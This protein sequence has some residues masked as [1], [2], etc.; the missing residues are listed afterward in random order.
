M[1]SSSEASDTSGLNHSVNSSRSSVRTKG[2]EVDPKNPILEPIAPAAPKQE[3]LAPRSPGN[4]SIASLK[5]EL[6]VQENILSLLQREN[7][8][9]ITNEKLLKK[10]IKELEAKNANLEA[11][12]SIQC[13]S[14]EF[15]VPLKDERND[16]IRDLRRTIS[17]LQQALREA[18]S[19]KCSLE[20]QVQKG[21][22]IRDTE[23]EIHR[24]AVKDKASVIK[25]EITATE[26]PAP[27]LSV[28]TQTTSIDYGNQ[29]IELVK[30]DPASKKGELGDTHLSLKRRIQ[31][32]QNALE[33]KDRCAEAAIADLK[34]ETSKLRDYYESVI[35][36]ISN[37]SSQKVA[38]DSGLQAQNN[39][40][41]SRVE[42]L[43]RSIAE[44]NLSNREMIIS[45]RS[46]RMALESKVAVSNKEKDELFVALHRKEEEMKIMQLRFQEELLARLDALRQEHNGNLANI[47]REHEGDLKRAAATKFSSQFYKDV[48][49]KWIKLKK[50]SP[51]TFLSTVVDRLTFLESYCAQKDAEMELSI[52]QVVQ[53]ADMELKLQKQREEMRI[54]EKNLQIQNFQ[55][56]LHHLMQL[57][58]SIR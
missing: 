9:L 44:A 17:E 39:A 29:P 52:G 40:L 31:Q 54:Q 58:S 37:S 42:E 46:E 2:S 51:D 48:R 23:S 35:M 47:R 18:E 4:E 5:K 34:K 24:E 50:E 8:V 38:E 21:S 1:P 53:V 28:S 3:S 41:T 55:Q 36:T 49:E 11:K 20:D 57:A 15:S 7:E 14:R 43:E 32:L 16:V 25:S 22:A 19:I 12:Y 33:D 45:L 10:E 26:V 30:K 6:A 56:E 27:K 13:S